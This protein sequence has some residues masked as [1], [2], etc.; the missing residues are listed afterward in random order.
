MDGAQRAAFLSAS[1][2]TESD[3]FRL[4]AEPLA[5][6]PPWAAG[7]WAIV[8]AW[9]P[10]GEQQPEAKNVRAGRELL[11][12]TASRPH[13]LGTNGEGGWAEPS[14]ILPGLSLR[15][16]AALGWRFGQA[17]VVFGVGRRAA[18]VWLEAGGV[19]VE[20]FWVQVLPG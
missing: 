19:R 3:R 14:V 18:L 15:A 9:N 6:A 13:L 11:A 2:G 16:A 4:A 17:A 7:T 10:G 1:Y 5:A 8:T 12:L 20:R